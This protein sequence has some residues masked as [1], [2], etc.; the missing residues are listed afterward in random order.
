MEQFFNIECKMSDTKQLSIKMENSDGMT[1]TEKIGI[2]EVCKVQCV[3]EIMKSKT[4]NKPI[5]NKGK[6]KIKT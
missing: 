6:T 2:L 1:I 5:R 3:E 4:D